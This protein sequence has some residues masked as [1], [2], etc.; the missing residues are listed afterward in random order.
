[1]TVHD[2]Q[3]PAEGTTLLVAPDEV[4]RVVLPQVA[5][6]G[7]VWSCAEH[8]SGLDLVA[9]QDVAGDAGPGA[10]GHHEVRLRARQPGTWQVRLVHRRAWEEIVADERHLTVFVS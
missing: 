9:E 1:M 7:Y 4:I 2:L 6:T 8:G 5:G 10:S 3:D